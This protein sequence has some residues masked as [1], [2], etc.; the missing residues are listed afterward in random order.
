MH[1]SLLTP[2]DRIAHTAPMPLRTLTQCTTV[3]ERGKVAIRHASPECSSYSLLY[4]AG[5]LSR[6]GSLYLSHKAFRRSVIKQAVQAVRFLSVGLGAIGL[7]C[8]CSLF[9]LQVVL[10][11]NSRHAAPTSSN[12]A[13]GSIF[14]AA[15]CISCWCVACRR[16]SGPTGMCVAA[17]EPKIA[18]GMAEAAR[19]SLAPLRLDRPNSIVVLSNAWLRPT[20]SVSYLDAARRPSAS[21]VS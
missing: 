10:H 16:I 8:I 4:V 19:W 12:H 20:S 14:S 5:R 15:T 9:T 6:F 13:N 7:Q 11:E 17:G 18:G 21:K 2:A 3:G 1:A